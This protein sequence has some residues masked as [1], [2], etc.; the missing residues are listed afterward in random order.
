MSIPEMREFLN[1]END[2]TPEQE[3]EIREQ[4]KWAV[5]S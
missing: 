4:N 1:I 3:A 2:L 5:K